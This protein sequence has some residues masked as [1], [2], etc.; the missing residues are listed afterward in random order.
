MSKK[1]FIIFLYEYNVFPKR[2]AN[3]A[4]RIAKAKA[5]KTSVFVNIFLINII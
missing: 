1:K 4:G 5:T 3:N 2:N